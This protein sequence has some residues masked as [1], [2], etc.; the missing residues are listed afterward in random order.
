MNRPIRWSV[1]WRS[2]VMPAPAFWEF[3]TLDDANEAAETIRKRGGSARVYVVRQPE[4]LAEPDA[5]ETL[6][7]LV[8]LSESEIDAALSELDA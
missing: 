4:L 5:D 7:A 8:T 1:A 2:T 6:P 3:G